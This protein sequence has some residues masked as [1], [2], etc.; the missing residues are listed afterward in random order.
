MIHTRFKSQCLIF[1]F[2]LKQSKKSLIVTLIFQ[3]FNVLLISR[4]HW[5]I[6]AERYITWNFLCHRVNKIFHFFNFQIWGLQPGSPLWVGPSP[7][8]T[9]KMTDRWFTLMTNAAG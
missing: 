3:Y 9:L 4:L 6:S 7:A 1:L 2:Y 5:L 8:L